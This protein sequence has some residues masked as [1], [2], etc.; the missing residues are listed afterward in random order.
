MKNFSLI[1]ISII[2]S[3][4]SFSQN[5]SRVK[6]FGNEN[7]MFRL[8]QLGVA[9]DHGI[10]KQGTFLISDFSKEEIQI[11]ND[12]EFNYEILI[13]DVQA[14]YVDMLTN[15]QPT[16]TQ[17]NATCSSTSGGSTGFSP[18]TP[19]NFNLG[20]MGGYLK[21]AEML[22]ELDAMAQQ[23]P[24]LIT[25]KAPISSFVTAGNRP[26]YHVKISDNPNTNESEPKIL[27]TAIHH[28]REPMSLME[29]IFF[30]WYVLENYGTN[31]EVT[32]LVNN[33]QLYFV[34]CI[35]P[36]GYVY[37]ET[38]NATGGGMWRKNRRLNSG[39]SY[40]VDLNR[41]YSYG[42]GTT[43]TSATQSNDTYR[44][45]AAFSEPETQAMRWLVQNHNFIS[46]FNAHT[47]AEDILFPIGTTTAEFAEHHDYFQDYTNHMVQYNG[48]T[49]M[50][51][52]GLYP[53]SGDSDDYMYKVD[54]GVGQK[55]TIF[56]HTPEVGT[57]FWQ[58]QA[59]IIP[60]CAEMVFPNLVLAHIAR[61]YN[62][63]ND[64]D[65]SAVATLTG[66]FNHSIKRL[67]REAGPVTV[68]IQP[69]LNIVTV[70]NS[71]VYNLNSQ[72]SSTGAISYTLNPNIQFGD[73]IK[74]ILKT[75]NGLWVKKDTIIKTYGSVTLQVLEDA[76]AS[77]NWTGTWGT[78]TSTYVSA[79]KSFADSPTGNYASNT[80][81][82]YTYVPT[83][84]LTNATS[85][86]ISFYAKWN[87]EADYDY[88]QFQVSIDNGANWIG[89]CGNYTVLGTSANG[90][91]QPN[92]QPVY[93]GVQSTWVLEEI[94]LSDYLGQQIKVRFQL[95]SD[96]GT[97]A[98]GFYF[99]DFKIFY[100]EGN[101]TIAPVA[102]FQ[103][104]SANTCLGNSISFSDFSS[105][106][107]TIWAWDFGDGS[108]SNQQN[109]SHT[110]LA[111]G[112]FTVSLTV[113]NSAGTNSISNSI[114]VNANPTVTLTS[115]DADNVICNNQ[116]IVQLT[117]NPSS[118][119]ISGNGVSGST[120]D[121]SIANIGINVITANYTDAN[122]CSAQSPLNLIVENCAG[123]NENS[124]QNLQVFPN[125]T[126]GIV[127][128]KNA[129]VDSEFLIFDFKGQLV[130]TGKVNSE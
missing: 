103:P 113:T 128:L 91:V 86:K 37:N 31:D 84:D 14:Y 105:N 87:L 76:T 33:T 9:V 52:S 47:Y 109:P 95:K 35:N 43:G 81:K 101:T 27:Y 16:V 90:S 54:V 98:D 79:T 26:I 108:T 39:G 78:T 75:D 69:L 57:A 25:T 110:Y 67:G 89:Q 34:P 68:S 2:F 127:T 121:P 50:K 45:T 8:G 125:P 106:V 55:D 130:K 77:T 93:E 61:N 71:V 29:T 83:I 112:S 94:N 116:G 17:K 115:N 62:V 60:T 102:S 114:V 117:T 13:P 28:A 122:G 120:F 72:Q 97:N 5:Y 12:Y 24:T 49:A 65:P 20:T 99:D 1:I 126:E 21:Y 44:G 56:A 63:V 6:V 59:E 123:L 3:F 18:A 40:G 70:G 104:S 4:T 22:A 64:T 73:Q 107:P 15:P 118:A 53:A 11:M 7:D 80:N 51:S 74:Y 46:A 23:Y 19:S 66:N 96:G 10:R 36:D 119:I 42:W 41:N 111:A 124:A 92:N 85:A 88:T 58:P 38:T 100:N 82:T 30:M 32:Y 129:L 48:Y